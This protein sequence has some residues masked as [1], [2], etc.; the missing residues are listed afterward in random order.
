M[1]WNEPGKKKSS[2]KDPWGTGQRNKQS[3][4]N[5]LDLEKWLRYLI[6]K[7]RR[8]GGQG[9]ANPVPFVI[10]TII[11][12]VV[13][14]LATGFYIVNSGQRGVVLEFGAYKTT[15]EPGPHWRFPDPIET[16]HLVDVDQNRSAQSKVSMLTQDENI[17]N[18][19]ISAQYRIKNADEYLFDVSDPNQTLRDVLTS[20]TRDIIGNS[21]MDFAVESGRT[22]IAKQVKTKL[23]H[24]LD[25]YKTG[26]KVTKVDLRSIQPPEQVQNA[27]ADAIK[28]REDQTRFLNQAKAYA[29]K[30]VSH[31]KSK[32]AQELEKAQAYKHKM[33]ARAQGNTARFNQILAQYLK[34]P[35][36]T[37]ERLYIQTMEDVL[38][39]TSKVFVDTNGKNILYLP[40]AKHVSRSKGNSSNADA[41]KNP[42]VS[43]S[44]TPT[45]KSNPMQAERMRRDLRKRGGQ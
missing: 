31:A 9:G 7:L 2:D 42:V 32:A 14:W 5:P 1:P 34:A 33:I 3:S 10:L 18:I 25:T 35:K 15:T 19:D 12:V 21:K 39:H 20:T 13:A 41:I 11:V 6:G 38:S 24:I 44:A 22:K 29:S 30:I 8:G 36:V 28:A 4:F 40:L 43:G 16:V 26:I 37:R 45:A 27:F 17:V 23:Q